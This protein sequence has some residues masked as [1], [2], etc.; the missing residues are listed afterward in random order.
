MTTP[1]TNFGIYLSKLGGWFGLSR[2]IY[3]HI[4]VIWVYHIVQVF[5]RFIVSLLLLLQKN[6]SN[7]SPKWPIVPPCRSGI[8]VT[9]GIRCYP[10][11]ARGPP[12]LRRRSKPQ[13]LARSMNKSGHWGGSPDFVQ[14]DQGKLDWN[15]LAQCSNNLRLCLSAKHFLDVSVWPIDRYRTHKC[16][17]SM[18]IYGHRNHKINQMRVSEKVIQVMVATL[19]GIQTH[20]N[21]GYL[22]YLDPY[23]PLNHINTSLDHFSSCHLCMLVT[24]RASAI[25]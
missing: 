7:N 18:D 13:K 24:I 1:D 2:S 14:K 15:Q 10:S 5:I 23:S 16:S 19:R 21:L 12:S 9:P 17:Q 3:I 4:Y 6:I 20:P 25:M 22:G 8:Q 11:N